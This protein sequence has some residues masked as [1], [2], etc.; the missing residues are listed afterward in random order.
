LEHP[1]DVDQE[2]L[3]TLD[4]LL[5]E[6][7]A[8]KRPV[9]LIGVGA[10]GL[11]DDSQGELFDPDRT[12]QHLLDE[13]MDRLRQRFGPEVIRRGEAVGTRQLDWRRDDVTAASRPPDDGEGQ[14]R[15]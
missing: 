15:G 14:E 10:A 9:R 12:R 3:R 4:R 11:V 1:T 8:D 6:A 13:A 2:V 7:L 5:D